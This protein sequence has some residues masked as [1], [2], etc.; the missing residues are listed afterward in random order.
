MAMAADPQV[1]AIVWRELVDAIGGGGV[2]G[3]ER[4]RGAT[5]GRERLAHTGVKRT[6]V[7]ARTG[8]VNGRAVGLYG[9]CRTAEL[10]EAAAKIAEG[11]G[12]SRVGAID[13]SLTEGGAG[14]GIIAR[15]EQGVAQTQIGLKRRGI[16]CILRCSGESLGCGHIVTHGSKRL[17]AVGK[18][19]AALAIGTVVKGGGVGLGGLGIHAQVHQGVA[20]QMVGLAHNLTGGLCRT[21]HLGGS[22]IITRAIS[23]AALLDQLAIQGSPLYS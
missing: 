9:V 1:K 6:C 5:G 2:K 19:R 20:A 21:E 14:I 12:G 7:V 22:G 8:K 11:G 17:A 16:G 3:I 13:G 4:G 23:G 10:N 15:L 18:Q